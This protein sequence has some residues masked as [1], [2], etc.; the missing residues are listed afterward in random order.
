TSNEEGIEKVVTSGGMMLRVH[1]FTP[2]GNAANPYH[3]T[4][5][6][7]CLGSISCPSDDPFEP[8]NDVFSATP[9]FASLDE[10]I[11][12]I[13]GN[14]DYFA[15][16]L[17]QG[18]TLHAVLS[19]VDAEGDLDLELDDASGNFITSSASTDDTETIDFPSTNGDTVF[20]R[21]LGFNG[22]TNTYRLHVE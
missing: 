17:T 10:T 3:V 4:S 22:A 7:I 21:V 18:C 5:N 11:G 2:D 13:C 12:A 8:N 19:F 14:D 16:Q 6:E 15:L 1:F 9:L 20:L